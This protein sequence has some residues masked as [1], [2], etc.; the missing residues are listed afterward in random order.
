MLRCVK[1]LTVNMSCEI[2]SHNEGQYY[3]FP[4]LLVK[5]LSLS[6]LI[7]FDTPTKIKKE[8]VLALL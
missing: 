8:D 5:L 2:Y 7:Q 6:F 1:F 3:L 4:E